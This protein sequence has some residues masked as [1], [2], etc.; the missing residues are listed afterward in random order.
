MALSKEQKQKLMLGGL[1]AI[2]LIYVYME[3]GLGPL[4]RKQDLTEK[5][6]AV[7]QPK[8]AEATK[9]IKSRDNLKSRVPQAEVFLSQVKRMIPD[10]SPEAWFPTLIA[11]YFK[12]RG[13]ERVTTRFASGVADPAVE[14][15]RRIN[16]NIEI[17]KA[18]FMEFASVFSDFEN[19]QPLVECPSILIEFNKDEPQYQRISLTLTN[20][21]RK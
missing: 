14:G 21:V 12:S 4:K 16:W 5:Q 19:D 10:G 15:H 2:G 3:F 17:P 7:L 1:M 18:D 13:N 9:K 6:I 20:S 8:I 11:D